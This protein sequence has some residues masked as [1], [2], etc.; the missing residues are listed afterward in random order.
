MAHK[1]VI[2][3]SLQSIDNAIQ[4]A[5]EEKKKIEDTIHSF[6]QLLLDEGVEIA[7][8]HVYD[9]VFYDTG[10]VRNSIEGR[11]FIKDNKAVI[12]ANS[13][14]AVYLEFGTGTF[15]NASAYPLKVDGVDPHSYT[16]ESGWVFPTNNMKYVMRDKKGKPRRFSS[17]T[18]KGQYIGFTRGIE[19]N[20]FM[21]QTMLY[22]QENAPDWAKDMFSNI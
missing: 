10:E 17:G 3:L 2:D 18:W 9:T 19:Q 7:K 15:R 20:R 11:M 12:V 4:W 16:D 8:S 21:Y 13:K 6:M 5:E 22:L 1:I 14:H